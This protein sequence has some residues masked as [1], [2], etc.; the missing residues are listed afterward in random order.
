MFF[1]AFNN[2]IFLP[3]RNRRREGRKGRKRKEGRGGGGREREIERGGGRRKGEKREGRGMSKK[4][5]RRKD[6]EG[7]KEDGKELRRSRRDNKVEKN[8]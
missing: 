7:I 6:T 3:F 8:A 4:E 5:R 1:K 2:S